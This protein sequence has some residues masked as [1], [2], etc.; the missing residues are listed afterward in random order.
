LR[1]LVL[2]D[3]WTFGQG[4]SSDQTFCKR[5]QAYLREHHPQ[6]PISV[7]NAGLPGL[8]YENAYFALRQCLPLYDPDIV[9]LAG[10][11]TTS[12]TRLPPQGSRR[13]IWVKLMRS[14]VAQVV[15]KEALRILRP[16]LVQGDWDKLPCTDAAVVYL[17]AMVA[18]V[19]ARGGSVLAFQRALDT[20][21]EGDSDY[22][23]ASD[24]PV[25]SGLQPQP[26]VAV[27][28]LCPRRDATACFQEKDRDHPNARGHDLMA[29]AL[30]K[31]LERRGWISASDR[32]PQP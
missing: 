19:T 12:G 21:A 14:R 31:V 13:S 9:L 28:T 4:V 2:G 5:L 3:S 18:Q 1:L 6:V 15:R 11:H 23:E 10:F 20:A 8:N 32:R 27:V 16:D 29:Q 17:R 7:V 22:V 25:L 24:N 26:R 30:F